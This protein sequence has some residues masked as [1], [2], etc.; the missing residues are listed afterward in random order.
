[1]RALENSTGKVQGLGHLTAAVKDAGIVARIW[2]PGA[3][4]AG[5]GG[6]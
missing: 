6:C 2:V 3:G 1:M 5:K 4:M